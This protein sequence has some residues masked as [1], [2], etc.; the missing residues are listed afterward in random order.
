MDAEAYAYY[1]L[2]G[3]NGTRCSLNL[4]AGAPVDPAPN[5]PGEA[6]RNSNI[7]GNLRIGVSQGLTPVGKRPQCRW[8]I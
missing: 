5:V 7:L 6:S 2:A 4:I 3:T 1:E 8:A